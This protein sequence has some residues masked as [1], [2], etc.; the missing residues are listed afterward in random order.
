MP[1]FRRARTITITSIAVT[2]ICVI[3]WGAIGLTRPGSHAA[4][5][6]I[7]VAVA[8]TPTAVGLWAV[9]WLAGGGIAYLLDKMLNQRS[10]QTRRRPD[11][12]TLPLRVV[13]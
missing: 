7:G 8:A 9:R 10:P 12:Q 5:Y 3:S 1:Q 2:V 4:S 11:A 6:A 13:R